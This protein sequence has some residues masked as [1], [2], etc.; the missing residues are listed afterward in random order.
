MKI[1]KGS[2]VIAVLVFLLALGAMQ[3]F[4]FEGL[5]DEEVGGCKNNGCTDLCAR[6]S[7]E[8]F[9]SPSVD[10]DACFCIDFNN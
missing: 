8:R 4:G 9:A 7:N 1:L 2:V 5:C 10:G 3:T 6:D